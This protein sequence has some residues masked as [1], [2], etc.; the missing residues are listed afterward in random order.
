MT[1]AADLHLHSRFAQGTSK[2][3]TFENLARRAKIKG[4]D[5]LASGDFT[6]PLWF[7]ET[8]NKLR[9]TGDGLFEYGGVR[10]VLGTEINCNS[11]EDGR[12][13]RVHLLVF[14]PT[15]ETVERINS[16]L[17][18]HGKLGGDGRPTIHLSPR[19]VL[20]LLLN[21]DRR[22]FVIPAHLW[23]PWFGLYGSKSGFDSLQEC[24]GDLASEVYAI[25]TGL[26]SDPAMNW[27]VSSLDEVSL[28]S[29]SDAH[30][31]AKMGREL[32]VFEGE[33]SYDGLAQALK[34]QG[35]AYTIE[36]FPE[37][38]KY[39]HSG[40]RRC[41]VRQTPQAYKQSGG[42]CTNCGRVSTLGVMQRLETLADRGVET[43]VDPSGY[44][45]S[46]N[47]RPPFRN[48]IALQEIIAEA[49]GRGPNT[50]TAQRSYD[51]LVSA[52]GNELAVLT[53]APVPDI[54]KAAEERVA[55]GVAR[56]RDGK[57][58]IEPGYDGEYGTVR[59]WP[60]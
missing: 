42:R 58:A 32:T 26:S 47:G 48:M 19:D 9:D 22:C 11:R 29:F 59:I 7:E 15:L 28:V 21:T 33:P 49:I 24:F 55:E 36:F 1:Y 37:E 2:H 30:S 39:H 56:V 20:D 13:R 46:D 31:P 17:A 5:L 50:K 57:V 45:R 3:L 16:A 40:H 51:A 4:V 27:R 18:R 43:R 52:F 53:E 6:H 34:T 41:G 23:T 25:E 8:R 10:F 60:D 12:S 54:A 38:G 44:V 14:A 35:I